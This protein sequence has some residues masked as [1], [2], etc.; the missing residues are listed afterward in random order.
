MADVAGPARIASDGDSAREYL[1]LVDWRRRIAG[2]YDAWRTASAA[3]PVA[4]TAAFRAG[5]DK[6]FRE[7]AQ[8]PLDSAASA[9]FGGLRYWPYDLAYRMDVV[10][11]AEPGL[12]TPEAR[13]G[14]DG[15]A[16]GVGL[17]ESHPTGLRFRR[18]GRV[19]LHGPL[20]GHTLG[21]YWIDAYG[22]GI[23]VPFRDATA[24]TETYGAGR[25]LLDTIKGADLGGDPEKGTFLL[26]FNMA[27]PPSCAY[28]PRWACP[29]APPDSHMAARVPVGERSTGPPGSLPSAA[30]ST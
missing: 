22:G 19:R 27:F 8:S 23:F 15:I 24:G 17:P 25:Y 4:A 21:V 12:A 13:A 28:N 16:S 5:R 14:G 26:D 18:I 9:A 2:L 3:D 1:A 10:L 6:L 20:E 7:H 30:W 29:L 11:E